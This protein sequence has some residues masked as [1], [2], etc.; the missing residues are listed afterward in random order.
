MSR[1][2]FIAVE[3]IDGAG[4]STQ[5][6][7]LAEYLRSRGLPVMA[8]KEPTAGPA[9]A[10]IRLALDRRL[11]GPN[12]AYHG[13]ETAAVAAEDAFDAH[14]LALL[15]AA[16]RI[17]HVRS[18]IQP[19]L[20]RGR[21]IV[22][23]RYVLSSLAYQG[24]PL[25]LDWVREINRFAPAPDLT[26]YLDVSV[27]ETQRRMRASRL[28]AELYESDLEQQSVRSGYEAA[29]AYH[30]RLLGPVRRIAADGDV[31]NVAGE[32]AAVVEAVLIRI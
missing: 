32:I 30:E 21:W 29:I 27:E 10:L 14:T 6:A 11:R 26:L 9:G 17:D 24:L 5:T 1:G 20:E 25:G 2:R 8:T 28:K 7:R 13:A 18:L 31:E 19:A 22:C 12:R 4:S 16:D 3:G 23:D 15:F